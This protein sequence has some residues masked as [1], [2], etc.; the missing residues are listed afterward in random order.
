MAE[1][2]GPG[3]GSLAVMDDSQRQ[4]AGA[5]STRIAG[6]DPR[7]QAAAAGEPEALE[8][9]C[10]AVLPRIRNLVRFL[11]R[12]DADVDDLA[13]DGMIEVLRALPSFR[14]ESAFTTWAD[15]IVVRT[16]L[17]SQR[18]A[19]ARAAQLRVVEL[20]RTALGTHVQADGSSYM[21][22]RQL[23]RV[24]DTLPD[25]QRRVLVLH[26]VVGMSVP[27]VAEALAVPFDTAKSRIRLG[28]AKLRKELDG[29]QHGDQ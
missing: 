18:R 8:A 9:L 19:R 17:H 21:A 5:S 28:M 1:V 15:R 23:V 24:L 4:N 12:G 2:I 27:E 10:R 22:R 7:V 20:E 16:T 14:G 3:S 29:G 26:H 6:D 11:V 13:Q 25:E